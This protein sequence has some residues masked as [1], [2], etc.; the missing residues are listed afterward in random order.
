M[1]SREA[2]GDF[3]TALMTEIDHFKK[4]LIDQAARTGV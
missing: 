2:T 3:K 4:K 1:T